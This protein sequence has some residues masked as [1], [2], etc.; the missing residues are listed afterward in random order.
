ME[1]PGNHEG[2]HYTT[3]VDEVKELKRTGELERAVA[4]LVEL[5]AATE[6]EA[7]ATSL[8]VAPWYYEQLAIVFRKLKEPT[9]ELE[10]LERYARQHHAPGKV[11]ARLEERLAAVRG[12][13]QL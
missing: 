5:I 2:R 12:T 8:G 4:L 13:V 11:P 10:T 7:R 9:K 6:A 3:Y 1:K